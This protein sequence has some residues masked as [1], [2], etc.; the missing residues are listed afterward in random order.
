M[1][2]SRENQDRGFRDATCSEGSEI[3]ELMRCM[4][5]ENGKWE[6]LEVY[7]IAV[8]IWQLFFRGVRPV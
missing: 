4:I 8:L 2:V 1:E 7:G 5:C 6:D 3:C